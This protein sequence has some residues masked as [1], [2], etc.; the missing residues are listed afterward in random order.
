MSS[1]NGLVNATSDDPNAIAVF[2]KKFVDLCPW[3]SLFLPK[4]INLGRKIRILCWNLIGKFFHHSG[5]I[6]VAVE[7][8]QSSEKNFSSQNPQPWIRRSVIMS[9]LARISKRLPWEVW[10]VVGVTTAG[11]CVAMAY[12]YQVWINHPESV[13]DKSKPAPFLRKSFKTIP[14]KEVPQ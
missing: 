4:A 8:H 13:V 9:L 2:W 5:H 3:Y 1:L 6:N 11:F 12:T 14:A 10:P 7:I